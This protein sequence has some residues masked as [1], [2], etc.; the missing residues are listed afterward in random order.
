M[1]Y[2]DLLV[3]I[4]AHPFWSFWIVL[5]QFIVIMKIHH[6]VDNPYLYGLAAIWFVPQDIVLNVVTMTIIGWEL[7]KEYTVTARMKRWQKEGDRGLMRKWRFGFATRLCRILN[8]YDM[9]HC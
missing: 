4:A 9:G 7:P 5:I 3:W 2:F 6:K 1:N 8:K